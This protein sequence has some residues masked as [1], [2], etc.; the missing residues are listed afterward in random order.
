[1]A[2]VAARGGEGLGQLRRFDL[3]RR[4][5]EKSREDESLKEAE[6]IGRKHTR[7]ESLKSGA[8]PC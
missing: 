7:S 4:L 3:T 2:E 1:M 6:I 5:K 8:P